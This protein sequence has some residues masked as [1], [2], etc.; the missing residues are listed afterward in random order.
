MVISSP[1]ANRMRV[2]RSGLRSPLRILAMTGSARSAALAK[3]A[4]IHSR[5]ASMAVRCGANA[6]TSGKSGRRPLG[7]FVATMAEDRASSTDTT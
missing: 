5:L 1:R 7:F 2:F 3:S 6:L 4:A